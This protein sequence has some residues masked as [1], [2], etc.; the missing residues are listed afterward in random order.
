MDIPEHILVEL[1]ANV[2]VFNTSDKESL[3]ITALSAIKD[4]VSEHFPN[5]SD[6]DSMGFVMGILRETP[7]TPPIRPSL[8]TASSPYIRPPVPPLNLSDL[9]PGG[10]HLTPRYSGFDDI[11]SRYNIRPPPSARFPMRDEGLNRFDDMRAGYMRPHSARFASRGVFGEEDDGLARLRAMNEDIR[12]KLDA[13]RMP[14]PLPKRTE[15]PNPFS[16]ASNISARCA[17]MRDRMARDTPLRD[18]MARV[19]PLRDYRRD[20]TQGSMKFMNWMNPEEKDFY[21]NTMSDEEKEIVESGYEEVH[22]AK[23][24]MPVRLKVLMSDIPQEMK[25][26]ILKKLESMPGPFES[27]K[28]MGWVDTLLSVPFGKVHKLPVNSLSSPDDIA[29]YIGKCKE[30]L[31]GSVLGHGPLKDVLACV[32]ASW[33]RT[34]GSATSVN[35]LGI[36]GPIGVGKTTIVR[37]GLAAAVDKPFAFIS[38]GGSSG[39]SLLHGHSFTYEGSMPGAIVDAVVSAGCVNPIILLDEVDKISADSRGEEVFNTLLHLL[40]PSQNTEFQDRFLKV[41]LDMSGAFFVLTYNDASRIPKVLR[42]RLLEVQVEDFSIDDKTQ[43]ASKYLIPDILS[44][45]GLPMEWMNMESEALK[46]IISSKQGTGMRAT[47]HALINIVSTLNMLA[48]SG[49]RAIEL[50]SGDTQGNGF[51]EMFKHAC[52]PPFN[53]TKEMVGDI[54]SRIQHEEDTDSKSTNLMY[55]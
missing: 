9:R 21:N 29:D 24:Q 7:P 5:V 16:H 8:G 42:D 31:D 10:D 6:E 55:C 11:S 50:F 12:A 34:D 32:I 28:Y 25:G 53:V 37:S 48:L 35:A 45:L 43:I 23:T 52:Q 54:L 27:A 47:R 4:I 49:E 1:L 15:S 30:T 20:S 18:R 19:N 39:G 3:R 26:T 2:D 22:N 33:I 46:D 40:D 38:C 41:P 36:K 13:N 44:G 51:V 17:I 14:S